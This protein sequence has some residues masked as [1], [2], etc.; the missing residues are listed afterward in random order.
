[1][2]RPGCYTVRQVTNGRGLCVGVDM[3]DWIATIDIG[4]G[5]VGTFFAPTH[6]IHLMLGDRAWMDL[7]AVGSDEPIATWLP[8]RP[9]NH[10]RDVLAMIRLHVGTMPA[11]MVP[12]AMRAARVT[13]N[14]TH[15][16]YL[17]S[18]ANSF[19]DMTDVVLQIEEDRPGELGIE[20]ELQR[21]LRGVEV[22]MVRTVQRGPNPWGVA[23]T[24]AGSVDLGSTGAQA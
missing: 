10:L 14:E 11:G 13:L 15:D 23:A 22:R 6:R 19:G 1:M 8:A 18:L 16:A 24:S 3:S 2:M 7:F 5:G 12:P 4:R 20:A 9:E 17:D 21:R